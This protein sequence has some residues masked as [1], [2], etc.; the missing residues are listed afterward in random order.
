MRPCV[1]IPNS[2]IIV[3]ILSLLLVQEPGAFGSDPV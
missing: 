2:S 3:L 1:V